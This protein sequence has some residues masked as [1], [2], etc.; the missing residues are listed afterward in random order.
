MPQFLGCA[1]AFVD[2]L[3]GELHAALIALRRLEGKGKGAAF[4]YEMELDAH[5]YGAM[6]VLDRWNAAAAAFGPHVRLAERPGIVEHAAERVRTAEEILI[7]TNRLIDAAAA[8]GSELVEACSVAFQTLGDIFAEE[9]A[10]AEPWARLGPMQPEEYRE[11]RRIFLED[12]AA[13]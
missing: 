6:I 11:A 7:R 8:Y 9:R 4:A 13:R 1:A 12:L 5:R 2:S 10:A 3:T